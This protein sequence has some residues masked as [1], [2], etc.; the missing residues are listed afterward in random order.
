MT[1]EPMNPDVK[2][3]WVEALRSGEYA[4]GRSVLHDVATDT[5]C[6]LGVL[7]ALAVKNGVIP[8]PG[9]YDK[10]ND[11][12]NGAAWIY[13]GTPAEV[14]YGGVAN[15]HYLP[16]AVSEWSGVSIHGDRDGHDGLAQLN[17]AGKPFEVIADIIE[18]E[19]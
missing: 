7:C 19:F 14:E 10:F 16:L 3:Q 6:C 2:R 13:G 1:T 8:P 9:E 12:D 18:A 11:I 4:Q 17:D 5:Y 15:A